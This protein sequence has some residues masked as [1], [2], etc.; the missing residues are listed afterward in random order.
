MYDRDINTGHDIEDNL[1]LEDFSEVKTIIDIIYGDE[2]SLNLRSLMNMEYYV[3][4]FMPIL[5]DVIMNNINT[6]K[7]NDFK[8]ENINSE[9]RN[10]I[11]VILRNIHMTVGSF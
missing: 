1:S 8:T 3:F 10:N 6:Y 9:L 2:I 11:T 7:I 4:I 5:Y